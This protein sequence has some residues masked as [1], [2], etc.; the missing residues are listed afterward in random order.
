M[1]SR[2]EVLAG[3]IVGGLAGESSASPSEEQQADREGQ[4][5]IQRA[6][7]GIAG[8]ITN[9]FPPV[10]DRNIP[11]LR[12][13]F[14]TFLRSNGKFPDYCDIGTNVFYEIYDWHIRNRQQMVVTRQVDNRYS[15]QFMFTLLILRHENEPNYIGFPYDKA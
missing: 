10:A 9:A 3:G 5:E 1:L 6:I 2:R 12:K 15:I 13:S 11:T 7:Q 4:R 8:S 14:E